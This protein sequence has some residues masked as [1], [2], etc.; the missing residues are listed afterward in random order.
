MTADSLRRTIMFFNCEDGGG[1]RYKEE[2]KLPFNPE[3]IEPAPIEEG[4][5]LF[6]VG[7]ATFPEARVVFCFSSSIAIA[8]IF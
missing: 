7:V 1:L 8:K 4:R 6:T 2:I 3:N 5:E